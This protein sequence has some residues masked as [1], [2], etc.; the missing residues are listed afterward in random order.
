M[1]DDT[2][3]TPATTA[4]R[5]PDGAYDRTARLLAG[6]LGPTM[7]ATTTTEWVNLRIWAEPSPTLTYLN[8]MVLFIAGITA[9][10][11]H[12]SRTR[13]WTTAVTVAGSLLLLSG[14]L[15][16]AFPAAPQPRDGLAAEG[17]IAA[18]L[19]FGCLLTWLGYRPAPRSTIS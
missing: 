13:S 7:I 17:V 18:V 16:M 10:R 4:H 9:L 15:R 19:G 12:H 14:L 8:G 1:M 6:I 3:A 11:L 5:A 2:L